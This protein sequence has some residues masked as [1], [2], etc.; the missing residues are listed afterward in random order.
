MSL[1]KND[2]RVSLV[3]GVVSGDRTVSAPGIGHFGRIMA[4]DSGFVDLKIPSH[5]SSG[6]QIDGMFKDLPAFCFMFFH[7]QRRL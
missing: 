2:R 3:G 1:H 5:S 4:D 7:C 6:K